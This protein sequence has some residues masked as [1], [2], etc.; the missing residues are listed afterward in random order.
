MQMPTTMLVIAKEYVLY[1]KWGMVLTKGCWHHVSQ[2]NFQT[3]SLGQQGHMT[4]HLV[5]PRLRVWKLVCETL[6]QQPFVRTIL[7]F[8]HKSTY[9][10]AII[11]I[12]VGICMS[13]KVTLEICGQHGDK[14][15][16]LRRDMP[17]PLGF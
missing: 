4:K 2:T 12:V 15:V 16:R 6:C 17:F 11:K 14:R 8:C 10:F 3:L 1:D 9:A 13:W 5:W 7:P